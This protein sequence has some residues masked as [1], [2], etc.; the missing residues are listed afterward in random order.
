MRLYFLAFAVLC[1]CLWGLNSG[2]K[3]TVDCSLDNKSV[4]A[5]IK[6]LQLPDTVSLSDKIAINLLVENQLS[7]CVRAVTAGISQ[8]GKD[9]FLISA[10]LVLTPNYQQCKCLT[11]PVLNT[12]VFFEPKV[13]G[14][15]VFVVSDWQSSVTNG[16]VSRKIVVR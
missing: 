11:E 3:P 1:L 9:T 16:N 7:G 2:C 6:E 8:Q 15:F 4:A 13:R 5:G 10:E 12:T 14:I